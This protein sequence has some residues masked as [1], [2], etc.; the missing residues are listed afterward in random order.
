MRRSGY[1]LGGLFA[2][3]TALC[4]PAVLAQD[5]GVRL[6]FGIENR[7]EISRNTDLSVPATG[8]D[9]LDATQLS[10]GITTETAIDRLE[11]AASAALDRR[12]LCRSGRDRVRLRPGVGNAVLS[13]R[14]ACR[15]P[16]HHGRIPP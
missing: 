6:V 16:R 4:A 15:R 9:V 13:P 5:G 1:A 11:F 12:E 14:S 10:F 8:T 2:A 7:L 3:T